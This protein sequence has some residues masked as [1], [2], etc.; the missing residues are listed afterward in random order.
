MGGCNLCASALFC[1]QSSTGGAAP[2][3]TYTNQSMERFG[4]RECT[5]VA[6]RTL[7]V[8]LV[9]VVLIVALVFIIRGRSSSSTPA[10]PTPMATPTKGTAAQLKKQRQ[11]AELIAFART[12]LPDL[13]K[14]AA[15]MDRTA[16]GAA[17]AGSQFAR[18]QVCDKLGAKVDA[19]QTEVTSLAWPTPGSPA[20]KWRHNIF[21]VYHRYLGAVVECR[22]AYDTKDAG[23]AA[24]AVSDLA[25]AA[26]LMH[27]QVNYAR[28]LSRSK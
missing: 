7:L 21:N 4:A 23:Q 13:V 17:Q 27:R 26:R 3:A 14:S 1:A 25:A 18:F 22:N 24:S 5:R 10:T 9:A 15:L 2:A 16:G 19:L 12:I 28:Y 8:V 20:R 11:H 6:R